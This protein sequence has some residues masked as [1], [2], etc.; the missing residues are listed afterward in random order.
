[1][2]IDRIQQVMRAALRLIVRRTQMEVMRMPCSAGDLVCPDGFTLARTTQASGDAR[3][4]A[5]IEAAMVGAGEPSGLVAPRL[6]HGDEFFAWQVDGKLVSFGWV[7][8]HERCVGPVRLPDAAGRAFLFNFCT[9][10]SHRGRGLYAALLIAVR[11]VLAHEA[12]TELIGE[13]NVLNTASAK[14]IAN[15]GFEPVGRI[16]Y[17]TI[18]KHWCYVQA[19]PRLDATDPLRC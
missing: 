2:N 16:A 13:V 15:V 10:P 4:L 18:F 5:L 6:T 17:L 3:Q 11:Q 1:M 8:H 14:G 7:M 12:V 9:L 19:R